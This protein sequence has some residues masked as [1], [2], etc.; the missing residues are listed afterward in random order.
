MW[1]GWLMN[2]EHFS[3]GKHV[4]ENS[5]NSSYRQFVTSGKI[6]YWFSTIEITV[7]AFPSTAQSNIAYTINEKNWR[8]KKSLNCQ[9]EV[10][11]MR[12]HC[13]HYT[14]CWVDKLKSF[15]CFRGSKISPF[16]HTNGRR[17]CASS[18]DCSGPTFV[19][20]FSNKLCI[21]RAEV[22]CANED[23][24]AWPI[25]ERM[26]SHKRCMDMDAPVPC[27]EEITK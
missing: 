8:K 5:W 22:S 20:T 4:I 2:K 26:P 11:S 18:N 25:S 10:I 13:P 1:F 15:I 21:R 19:W 24:S 9:F 7:L 14:Q 17:W 23:D 27:T 16:L 12:T 6:F 3:R